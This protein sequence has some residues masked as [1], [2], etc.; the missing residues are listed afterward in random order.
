MT[1]LEK[2][3]RE[4]ATEKH[5]EIDQRR[6]YTYEPYMVHPN[7]VADLVRTVDHT[8]EMIAAALLHDTVEDTHTSLDEIEKEFGKEV[9]E[10]VEM[11]T[12]VSKQSDGNRK[13][14]NK[15]NRHH[16]AEGSP[17]AKTIKLA[18]IIDNMKSIIACDPD[19]A[20]VFVFEAKLLLQVLKDGDPKLWKMA[21]SMANHEAVGQR[22]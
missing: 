22:L 14:R 1:K 19:F 5:E 6:K 18:D 21:H 11:L 4:F 17:Q 8:P 16:T 15:I 13:T 2:R 10:L 9:S 20:K 12:D 7:A 3:A